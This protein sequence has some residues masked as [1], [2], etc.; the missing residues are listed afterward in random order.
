MNSFFIFI[1]FF[2]EIDTVNEVRIIFIFIKCIFTKYTFEI[3]FTYF[4]FN[5]ILFLNNILY[6]L[7]I[8]F[9]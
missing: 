9:K 5:N 2:N 8:Y 1:I 4:Y 3:I 6:I 7:N